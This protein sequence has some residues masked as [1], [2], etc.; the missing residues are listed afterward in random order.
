MET[1]GASNKRIKLI[2]SLSHKTARYKEKLVFLEGGRLVRD[3]VRYGAEILS[4][5]Y[6]EGYNGEFFKAEESFIIPKKVFGTLTDTV[7]P[8]GVCAIARMP[9]AFANAQEDV[10]SNLIVLCD[11]VRDPGNMGTVIR[12]A[13]AFGAGALLITEGCTDPFGLKCVRASMGSV[14]A[15]DIIQTDLV[16]LSSLKENGWRLAAGILGDNCVPLPKADLSG[17]T[18]IAVGSEADGVSDG[19]ANMCNL[20]LKIPMLGGAESFNA[21]VAAGIMMYEYRRQNS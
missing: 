5:F 9:K 17:K 7:T 1:L 15:V 18:V 6:C 11:N 10:K 19:I 3:S 12:T 14:F 21:A 16:K 8:Q 2:K 4:A 20:K 13:H